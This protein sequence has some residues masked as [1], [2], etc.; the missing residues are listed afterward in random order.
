MRVG[1]RDI[2]S[3]VCQLQG[4]DA[5]N[6]GHK[7]VNVDTLTSEWAVANNV[8]SGVTTLFAEG[9]TINGNRLVVP[10]PASRD[11]TTSSD[12]S[13]ETPFILGRLENS[14]NNNRRLAR[15]TGDKTILAVRVVSTDSETSASAEELSDQIFGT[16]GDP[17]NIVSQYKACSNNKLN[18]GPTSDSRATNGVYTVEIG[19]SVKSKNEGEAQD[20]VT[21]QLEKE[22]GNLEDQYDHVMICLPKGTAGGNWIGKKVLS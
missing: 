4:Q 16:N 5:V 22:L 14:H 21:A 19:Q 9:A 11:T 13:A 3:I 12:N 20:L 7:M 15:T 17:A 8:V 18:F 1:D 10:D 2:T 6:H